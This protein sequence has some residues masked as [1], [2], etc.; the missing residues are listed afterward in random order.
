MIISEIVLVWAYERMYNPTRGKKICSDL[1]PNSGANIC[2][3]L[4]Y[5]EAEVKN[6]FLDFLIGYLKVHLNWFGK[7]MGFAIKSLIT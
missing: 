3:Q 2:Y 4:A 1:E 6:I 5:K 7:K